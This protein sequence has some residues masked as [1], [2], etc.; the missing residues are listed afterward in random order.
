MHWTLPEQL[1][2]AQ[3]ES[4]V[5][6]VLCSLRAQGIII[7]F[8]QRDSR[9]IDF[10]IWN[11]SGARVS[12]E[13]KT[14]KSEAVKHRRKTRNLPGCYPVILVLCKKPQL[15]VTEFFHLVQEA[16]AFITRLVAVG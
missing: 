15:D 13:V 4:V 3:A 8:E 16:A 7:S 14:S 10:L 6:F 9:G 12:L 11:N 1:K 5:D 2:G